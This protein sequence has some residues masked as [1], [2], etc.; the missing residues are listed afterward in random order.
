MVLPN[1]TVTLLAPC[2]DPAGLRE[3]AAT[4][5][6]VSA[7]AVVAKSVFDGRPETE[8][9]FASCFAAVSNCFGFSSGG[10]CSL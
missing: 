4:C 1:A 9:L 10:L 8:D 7:A 2:G 5:D 6:A 3:C